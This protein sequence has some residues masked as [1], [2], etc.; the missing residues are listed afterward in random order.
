MGLL[1]KTAVYALFLIP[2]SCL[3]F[4]FGILADIRWPKSLLA[5][6]IMLFCRHYGVDISESEKAANSFSTFNEFFTRPLKKGAR[7]IDSA[8][9][10]VVSPVDAKI[11]GIGVLAGNIAIQSKGKYYS[12]AEL[13]L[14]FAWM[15]M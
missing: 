10:A 2:K 14:P 7:E 9:D 3:S 11:V 1:R 5:P 15:A 13:Y 8:A 12:A 4:F 6:A